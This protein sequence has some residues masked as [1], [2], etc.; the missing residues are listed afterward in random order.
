MGRSVGGEL[1]SAPGS[2]CWCRRRAEDVQMRVFQT[3]PTGFIGSY[4]IQEFI[5]AGHSAEAM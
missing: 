2:D 3:G 5:D 4:L 1:F